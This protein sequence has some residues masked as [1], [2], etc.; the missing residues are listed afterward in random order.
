MSVK[1]PLNKEMRN[2]LGQVMKTDKPNPEYEKLSDEQKKETHVPKTIKKSQTIR[3]YLLMALSLKFPIEDRKEVFWTYGLGQL[4][5]DEEKNIVEIS[6]GKAAF[7][8]RVFEKNKSKNT[9]PMGQD[10]EVEVFYPFELGQIIPFFMSEKE[11][12]DNDIEDFDLG[13]NEEKK[14]KETSKDD[15]KEEKKEE[16]K[17]K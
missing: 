15:P 12:Q 1:I 16:S 8:R 2:G 11:R 6:D 5:S 14:E 7:L 3:D 10:V 17:K 4:F 13:L 9:T